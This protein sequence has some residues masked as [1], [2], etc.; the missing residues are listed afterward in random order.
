M[1]DEGSKPRAEQRP[2]LAKLGAPIVA[3]SGAACV[4]AGCD[5]QGIVTR[6]RGSGTCGMAQVVA[7]LILG[8]YGHEAGGPAFIATSLRSGVNAEIASNRTQYR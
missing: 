4:S 3:G 1:G 2:P 8:D 6:A 5:R 7:G